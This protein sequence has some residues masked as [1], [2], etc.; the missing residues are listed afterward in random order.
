ME[1]A[2]KKYL[3]LQQLTDRQVRGDFLSYEKY[4][5]AHL[6][7]CGKY[8]SHESILVKAINSFNSLN[9]GNYQPQTPATTH[10]MHPPLV[11]NP[12]FGHSG[13]G[14]NF[15]KNGQVNLNNVTSD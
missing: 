2:I 13:L 14:E 7:L 1:W 12:T 11:D 9:G 4:F 3:S 10:P 6:F 8:S 5:E 15:R